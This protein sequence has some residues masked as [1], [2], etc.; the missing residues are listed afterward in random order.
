MEERSPDVG[1]RKL[2][3]VEQ[4]RKERPEE[5][6]DRKSD[7]NIYSPKTQLRKI[8]K[9]E[10]FV[11]SCLWN[12][13]AKVPPMCLDIVCK[14]TKIVHL[15]RERA[16]FGAQFPMHVWGLWEIPQLPHAHAR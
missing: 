3:R 16:E 13:E 12:F 2:G 8:S 4:K 1:R 14:V 9:T 5:K 7:S 10:E 15:G 6:K 11:S